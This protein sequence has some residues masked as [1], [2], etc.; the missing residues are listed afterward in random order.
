MEASRE[1]VMLEDF[2]PPVLSKEDAITESKLLDCLGGR[3]CRCC[4]ESFILQGVPMASPGL[5][6]LTRFNPGN[7][8]A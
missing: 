4:C 6:S 3:D 8:H 1:E 5:A 7:A 2:E